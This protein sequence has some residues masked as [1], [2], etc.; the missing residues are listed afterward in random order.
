MP[1]RYLDLLQADQTKSVGQ[2]REAYAISGLPEG[3]NVLERVL[4]GLPAMH[5]VN[6]LPSA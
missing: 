3:L 5:Q 6:T 4:P 2:K 1:S